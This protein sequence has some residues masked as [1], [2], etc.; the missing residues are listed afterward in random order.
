ML[1]AVALPSTCS[2]CDPWYLNM[3]V[4]GFWANARG[5]Q[6]CLYPSL[7]LS[8]SNPTQISATETLNLIN[9]QLHLWDTFTMWYEPHFDPL[10]FCFPANFLANSRTW[11]TVLPLPPP[12][13]PQPPPPPEDG[14]Q[15]TGEL[16]S[17]QPRGKSCPRSPVGEPTK[18]RDSLPREV[19]FCS[20][21]KVREPFQH[22]FFFFA[23]R[24][25]I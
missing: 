15:A 2:T 24:L 14:Q 22:F 16:G 21:Q 20:F 1:P 19:L 7:L 10:L 3:P 13:T 25:R 17:W 18:E 8:P 12:H 4:P 9:R 6:G 23:Y 11:T 5:K